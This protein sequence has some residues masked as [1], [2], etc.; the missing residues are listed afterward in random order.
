MELI[1]VIKE[2]AGP[3]PKPPRLVYVPEEGPAVEPS[4]IGS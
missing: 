1:G 2:L 4:G 3:R